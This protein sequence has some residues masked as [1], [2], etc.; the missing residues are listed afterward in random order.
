[1]G[2]AD[3]ASISSHA[4]VDVVALCDVDTNALIKAKKLH[5]NAKVYK[6]YRI[7]LKEM[8]NE[9]DQLQAQVDTIGFAC[10]RHQKRS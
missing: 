1:M 4:K 9:I 3:L 7:M 6:D 2:A 8:K 10:W 5:P